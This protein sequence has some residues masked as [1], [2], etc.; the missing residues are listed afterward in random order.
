MGSVGNSFGD[1]V[2]K[3]N[4]FGSGEAGRTELGK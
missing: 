1:R 2:G 3:N 4:S